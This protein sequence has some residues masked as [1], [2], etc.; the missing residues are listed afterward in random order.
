MT[1]EELVSRVR[2]GI[3]KADNMLTLYNQNRG[4]IYT[5]AKK[6][7]GYAELEDLAQEGYIGLCNAVDSYDQTGGVPFVSYAWTCIKRQIQR[8]IYAEKGF[9]EYIQRLMSQYKIFENDFILQCGRKPNTG[10]ICHYMGLSLKQA[11]RLAKSLYMEQTASIDSP[12]NEE[13]VTLSDTLAGDDDVE[14][15]VLDKVQQGQLRAVLWEAV[16]SLPGEQ[17][18]V[19][20]KRYRDNMTLKQTMEELKIPTMHRARSA[21]SQALRRLRKNG[22]LRSFVE[23][24]GDGMQGTGAEVFRR[25]W[26]SA[27]E[28]VALE[29]VGELY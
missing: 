14:G 11:R 22:R 10:E 6:Y 28:R 5:I 17:P 29:L 21:E 23:I 8:Y 25:T 19:I 7:S 2:A 16:D 12:I 3:D 24:R 18:G 4:M 27:T 26:T 20:R 15:S 13:G 1:N 9:P